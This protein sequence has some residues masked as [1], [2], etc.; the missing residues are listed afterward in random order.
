MREI[1]RG[2]LTFKDFCAGDDE[3]I[4]LS[5]VVAGFQGPHDV[6][7]A[8]LLERIRLTRRRRLV[9]LDVVAVDK[10]SIHRDQVAGFQVQ[11]VADQNVVDVD[12][13]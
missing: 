11:H 6:V 4:Q 10:D 9:T 2:R 3:G 5:G 7:A 8:R 12:H 1:D 13:E